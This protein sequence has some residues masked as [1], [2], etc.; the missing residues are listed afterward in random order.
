[1]LF[2]RPFILALNDALIKTGY[3]VGKEIIEGAEIPEGISPIELMSYL[4]TIVNTEAWTSIEEP[5][6][7]DEKHCSFNILWCPLQDIYRAF[8]CR[9]QRYMVQG[10]IN[11][12]RESNPYNKDYQVRF[13]KTI[14]AGADC[15]RFEVKEKEPGEPDDWQNYS[16]LLEARA[17]KR[18]KDRN[19]ESNT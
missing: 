9:V 3:D 2:N 17:L 18:M 10:I 13:T 8:D 12:F 11:A 14:P 6:I 5:T 4:A 19:K 15:C 7:E 16:Q 1:M